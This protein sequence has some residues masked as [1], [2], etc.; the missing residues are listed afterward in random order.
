[1]I[2]KSIIL[3]SLSCFYALGFSQSPKDLEGV[4]SPKIEK[5]ISGMFCISSVKSEKKHIL[6][7][8]NNIVVSDTNTIACLVKQIE[9][10][11]L[12]KVK[13]ITADEAKN[14]GLKNVPKDGVLFVTTKKGY[15]FDFSCCQKNE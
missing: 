13:L 3:F 11:M 8:I 12:K 5:E 6:L 14:R 4:T 7:V 2:K 1:M 10:S 9:I 15:Y